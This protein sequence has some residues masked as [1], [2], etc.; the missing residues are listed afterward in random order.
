MRNVES[1]ECEKYRLYKLRSVEN[2]RRKCGVIKICS[3]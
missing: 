3:M 2:E 1:G